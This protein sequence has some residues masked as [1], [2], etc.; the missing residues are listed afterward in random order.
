LLFSDIEGSTSAL[1]A[2]G[3]DY[4]EVLSTHRSILRAAFERWH[5]R[6]MG[7][8]GDS[9]FVVF[10][11]VSDALNA[12]A[13]SQRDLNRAD[14][15]PAGRVRVRMGM[16]TGEP[17]PHEDG[18]VG[19]DVHL[20][21]RIAGLA[22]GGQVVMTEATRRI[23]AT[24][25]PNGTTVVDL[26]RHRLKDFPE[27]EHLYQLCMDGLDRSFPPLRSLGRGS[28]LP[29]PSTSLV[30]REA[31]IGEVSAL[32]TD[33]GARVVTLTGPGGAGKTRLALA[34]AAVLAEESADGVYFVPL[35]AVTS[36]EVMWTTLADRLGLPVAGRTPQD[37]V[38][39]L[40]AQPALL[41]LD[42]LEQ[43]PPA[44]GVVAELVKAPEVRILAT[45]RRP[46][47]V[48][49]EFQHPVA[50]LSVT[51]PDSARPAAATAVTLF[52]ERAR[53]VR[54]DL[55]LSQ[56]D[57]AHV[58]EI[59]RLLDG[60]PLAIELAAARMKVFSPAALR[61]RLVAGL[62]L[63]AGRLP[64]P[65]RHRTLNTTVA[66]SYGMLDPELQYFF[67]QLGA[68]GGGFDV[69]AASALVPS[70]DDPL[71]ALEE[72]LDVSL[73]A[74]D[75]RPDG[76]PRFRL[77]RTI[78]GFAR[79]RLIEAGEHEAAFRRHGEHYLALVEALTPQLQARTH[80]AA[81]DR[82]GS[83]LDNIRA[84]LEW[85]L[86]D[87]GSPAEKQVIGLRVCQ[88]MYRYWY[89]CG[90]QAEGRRWMTRAVTSSAGQ[91]SPESMTTL[92]GL[93]V[94]LV[95]H[96]EL[97]AGRDALSR[98]LDYWRRQGDQSK[99]VHN[100]SSLAVALRALE[101]PVAARAMLVESVELARAS[102]DTRRLAIALSNL[103]VMDV[104]EEQP[105]AALERLTEALALDRE[106][107]DEWAVVADH[108]NI[109][110]ALLQCG[111]AREAYEATRAV[112]VEAVGL[113][114]ADMTAALLEL[115]SWTFAALD[116]PGRAARMAG[117]AAALRARE[118]LP[119]DPADAALL[120]RSLR[121]VRRPGDEEAWAADMA[122]GAGCS[123]DE[124]LRQAF[125]PLGG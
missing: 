78:S 25:L 87:E 62:E 34:V 36:A 55:V 16:H 125:G 52:V 13:E 60:L 118:E 88:A 10:T 76:E 35:E 105:L 3:A 93:G 61:S 57:L 95:Q 33:G 2:L 77:L 45:S 79:R 4:A 104:D 31:E 44:S 50:P 6:E 123:T 41:V 90:D 108:L 22:H 56:G 119:I 23:A 19:L 20:A 37:V 101:Q 110:A 109:G 18:Y 122:I 65:E 40:T 99:I 12:A 38:A 64:L 32:L 83:E 49:G 124:T 21:A 9:F 54:P 116:D 103:A 96:G 91:E 72:L 24:H 30:G 42:N 107:G 94:L 113:G 117:A 11:S 115:L 51:A 100:L 80:L 67:R 102:A 7:T 69:D 82:I 114:D 98:S 120:E 84:V 111:R 28:D 68:F 58:V 86:P 53:M 17:T 73:L 106:L 63:A 14:W 5:G 26:G 29:I 27:P 97:E 74:V 8:E 47:H 70:S 43:L 89:R 112:A 48:A 121:Q 59:C 66:W 75:H 15:P 85:A 71:D 39:F 92:Q 1:R 81:K 46:L